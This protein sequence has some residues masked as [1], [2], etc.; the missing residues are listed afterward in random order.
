MMADEL[1]KCPSC[2]EERPRGAWYSCGECN[3][4]ARVCGTCGD[5]LCCDPPGS[6]VYAVTFADLF[7]QVKRDTQELIDRIEAGDVK[8]L[9]QE[10]E[11]IKEL[12]DSLEGDPD[13]PKRMKMHIGVEAVPRDADKPIYAPLVNYE[14]EAVTV[15]EA[16]WQMIRHLEINLD[17]EEEADGGD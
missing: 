10:L 1:A 16:L 3:G 6:K 4:A 5:C 13:D 8:P 7:A 11:E 12:L 17:D 2:E 9:R 14:C 15:R